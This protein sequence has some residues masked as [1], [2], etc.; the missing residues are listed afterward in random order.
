MIRLITSGA[1][2]SGK[3]NSPIFAGCF[4]RLDLILLCRE[5][6]GRNMNGR[7]NMLNKKYS[8]NHKL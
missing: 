2:K 3:A 5:R 7:E 4:L 6:T 1:E 8:S